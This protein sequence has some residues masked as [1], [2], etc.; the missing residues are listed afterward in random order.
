VYLILENTK[1]ITRYLR[2]QL[3]VEPSAT[4][5]ASVGAILGAGIGALCGLIVGLNAYAPTAWFAVFEVGAPAAIVGAF[6]GYLSGGIAVGLR[7]WKRR[8]A[9]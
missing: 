1:A 9:R 2:A 3:P 7:R 5:Y 6:L 8:D 4:G